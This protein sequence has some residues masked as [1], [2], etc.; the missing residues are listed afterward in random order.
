[1]VS[2]ALM[3]KDQ[4][5]AWLK[6]SPTIEFILPTEIATNPYYLI[7]GKVLEFYGDY[8]KT[9]QPKAVLKMEWTVS[10]SAPEGM[11]VLSQKVYPQAISMAGTSP[12][13]LVEGWNQALAKVLFE[14]E[15]DLRS[16]A[17]ESRKK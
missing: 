16:L 9:D 17:E 12:R 2:P 4:T 14:F 6:G 3:I 10:K 1:M 13:S 11:K 8:R 7:D 15:A 5:Q